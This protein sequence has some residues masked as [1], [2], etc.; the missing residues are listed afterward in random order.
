ML[1]SG[2]FGWYDRTLDN[3]VVG[4]P[5]DKLP[6]TEVL[7]EQDPHLAQ[8]YANV[9]LDWKD[10]S[11]TIRLDFVD[12]LVICRG[13]RIVTN[14]SFEYKRHLYEGITT[15]ENWHVHMICY[16]GEVIFNNHIRHAQNVTGPHYRLQDLAVLCLQAGVIGTATR[17]EELESQ[18]LA[19]IEYER[20]KNDPNRPRVLGDLPLCDNLYKNLKPAVPRKRRSKKAA[21]AETPETAQPESEDTEA[22]STP[23]PR[24]SPRRRK[25]TESSS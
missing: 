20:E 18:R 15:F 4:K 25:S 16:D 9:I 7:L 2:R 14:F 5:I 19:K 1:G 24:R 8:T 13:G 11:I 22:Q 6:T 12:W 17:E 10:R 21:S 23:K 3:L